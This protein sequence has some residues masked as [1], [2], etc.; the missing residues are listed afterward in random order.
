VAISMQLRA[1]CAM[2][3]A[4]PEEM[5]SVLER[6]PAQIGYLFNSQQRIER[7]LDL[8]LDAENEVRS[9]EDGYLITFERCPDIGN[10]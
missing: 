10:G 9:R 5:G 8:L 3:G 6:L 7:K 2:I 4:N 1:V